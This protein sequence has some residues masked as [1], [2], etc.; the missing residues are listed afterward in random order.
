MTKRVYPFIIHVD[1]TNMYLRGITSTIDGSFIYNNKTL[2]STKKQRM[3]D[4]CTMVF[5]DTMSME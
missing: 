4:T 1:K 5:L 3:Q 2:N